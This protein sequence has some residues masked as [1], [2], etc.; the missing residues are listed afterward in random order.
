MG[1]S[2]APFVFGGAA[3][4]LAGGL[5]AYFERKQEADR[6]QGLMAVLAAALQGD[7]TGMPPA[8]N[9]PSM[10]GSAFGNLLVDG[11]DDLVFRN[12][13]GGGSS[14]APAPSM[15]AGSD[16]GAT[17]GGLPSG[18]PPGDATAGAAAQPAPKLPDWKTLL[19]HGEGHPH[20]AVDPI[21]ASIASYKPQKPE[22]VHFLANVLLKLQEPK[23]KI[24]EENRRLVNEKSLAM[25]NDMLTGA[26]NKE[27]INLAAQDRETA[28]AKEDARKTI[29]D[30]AKQS[31]MDTR[32]NRAIVSLAN[33]EGKDPRDYEKAGLW[34]KEGFEALRDRQHDLLA[35]GHAAAP[36]EDRRFMEL[37]LRQ[38]GLDI[39]NSMLPGTQTKFTMGDV[40]TLAASKR[41]ESFLNLAYSASRATEPG[42]MERQKNEFKN[43]LALKMI[44]LQAKAAEMN[45][46]DYQHEMGRFIAI[47][48]KMGLTAAGTAR[49]PKEVFPIVDA[50]QAEAEKRIGP[51]KAKLRTMESVIV[52]A[53][54]AITEAGAGGAESVSLPQGLANLGVDES[55]WASV[56]KNAKSPLDAAMRIIDNLRARNQPV[57]DDERAAIMNEILGIR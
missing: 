47:A 11:R 44:D 53:K 10:A 2:A 30:Q 37:W 5:K 25:F 54:K 39:V 35:G 15:F 19:I 12:I 49:D 1:L 55:I 27:N 46:A 14:E 18:P 23:T 33:L 20:P 24:A 29:E 36:P 32:Y 57:S 26:R 52:D 50:Y 7:E 34:G 40:P 6:A 17:L 22:D 56:Q 45:N 28:A 51:D 41:S 9:A 21:R 4:G 38:G 43:R 31:A 42:R 3:E 16:M 8:A 48:M 13:P